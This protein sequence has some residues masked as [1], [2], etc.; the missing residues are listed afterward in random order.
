MSFD[1]HTKD[2]STNDKTNLLFSDS[3]NM[4]DDSLD[5]PDE[6]FDGLIDKIKES[7][8]TQAADKMLIELSQNKLLEKIDYTLFKRGNYYIETSLKTF[9]IPIAKNLQ[10]L[11]KLNIKIAPELI[12]TIEKEESL[13]IITKISGTINGKIKP[14]YE[15]GA[16]KVSPKSKHDA[17]NDMKKLTEEG[18]VDNQNLQISGWYYTAQNTIILPNWQSLRKIEENESKE[19]ILDTYRRIIYN[20]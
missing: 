7:K 13:Y 16:E 20:E 12:E 9:G 4:K 11:N 2:N 19:E 17:Y 14:Y 18:Y 5:R 15:N 3:K 1:F 8:S 10:T 6:F